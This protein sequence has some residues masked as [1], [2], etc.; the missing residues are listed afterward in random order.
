MIL[1]EES[2]SPTNVIDD[3]KAVEIPTLS[4]AQR[5]SIA[6][7]LAYAM[8]ELYPTPWLPQAFGKK[9]VYFFVRKNGEV[10]TES[11]FLLCQASASA[12]PNATNEAS[13]LDPDNSDALLALGILIMELWFG[14]SI[15]SR[16]FWKEHC[17]ENGSEKPFTR[18]TAAIEW[19]KKAIDEAGIILHDVTYRCI[20][21]NVGPT[22]IDLN[23]LDCVRAV[24]DQIITPLEGL[25]AHFWPG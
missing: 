25:L 7:I 2:T 14:Q 16:P 15:E 19:Q 12:R 4:R 13:P 6:L 5:M 8:L 17:Q 10:V 22:T 3:E 20:R 18:F 1:G 21:G 24:L 9:D 11:P 23:N